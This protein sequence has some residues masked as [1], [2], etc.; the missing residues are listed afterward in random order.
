MKNVSDAQAKTPSGTTRTE[1]ILDD[2]SVLVGQISKA[3]DLCVSNLETLSSALDKKLI[4]TIVYNTE[5]LV[6]FSF[7]QSNMLM[8]I[9]GYLLGYKGINP[10][11]NAASLLG[12]IKNN[13]PL[14]LGPTEGSKFYR[15]LLE[16]I[17]AKY[18]TINGADSGTATLNIVLSSVDGGNLDSLIELIKELQNSG[19]VENIEVLT[20]I[21]SLMQKLDDLGKTELDTELISM[22]MDDVQLAIFN[23]GETFNELSNLE[24]RMSSI[25]INV[26]NTGFDTLSKFD[27][28]GN[29]TKT[30]N[31][32]VKNVNAL[33]NLINAIKRIDFK[34][35]TAS[36]TKQLDILVA[37][38]DQLYKTLNH[39]ELLSSNDYTDALDIFLNDILPYFETEKNKGLVERISGI[40]FN[41]FNKTTLKEMTSFEF[42]LLTFGDV[43]K[44]IAKML[45]IMIIIEVYKEDIFNGIN[46]INTLI[47][48]NDDY[49]GLTSL[50]QN[51]GKVSMGSRALTSFSK[52]MTSIS[53]IFTSF[54]KVGSLG[55]IAMVFKEP[56]IKA[57]K[58][59]PDIIE[60][61]NDN[62][63]VPE[64]KASID[65]IHPYAELMKDLAII[66]G[67]VTLLG[68]ISIPAIVGG[69]LLSGAIYTIFVVL[70]GAIKTI[71]KFVSNK[72]TK[73]SI[74][75]MK[76]VIVSISLLMIFASI[77]G[78][79][80]LEYWDNILIFLGMFTAFTVAVLGTITL[81]GGLV[82]KLGAKGGI[83]ALSDLSNI[84]VTCTFCMLAGALFMMIPNIESYIWSFTG[85]LAGFVAALLGTFLLVSLISGKRMQAQ[86]DAFTDIIFACTGALMIGALFMMIPNMWVHVIEFGILLFVFT[87]AIL[88]TFLW[89]SK[90]GG[91][92]IKAQMDEFSKLVAICA[93]VLIVGALFMMIP[94]YR[95]NAWIF[96]L[97]LG[98][99]VFAIVGTI[100]LYSR[101]AKHATLAALSLMLFTTITAATLMYGANFIAENGTENIL[102]F[103]GIVAGFTILMVLSMILLTKFAKNIVIGTLC[104]IALVGV[105]YLIGFALEKIAEAYTVFKDPGEAFICLG[106]TAAVI[107]TFAGVIFGIGA[108]MGTGVG[109]A[110]FAAGVAALAA[111][112]GAVWTVGEAMKSISDGIKSIKALSKEEDTINVDNIKNLIVSVKD[113]AENFDVLDKISFKNIER[114]SKIIKTISMSISSIS[115]VIKDTASLKIPIYNNDGSISGYRKLTQEDFKLVSDNVGL[116]VTSLADA[117][118][119]AY[120]KN[121]KVFRGNRTKKVIKAVKGVSNILDNIANG[122]IALSNLEIPAYKEDGSLASGT[123]KLQMKTI[124]GLSKNVEMIITSFCGALTSAYEKNEELFKEFR[125]RKVLKALRGVTSIINTF[126]DAIIK[127]ANSEY[128]QYDANGNP[129]GKKVHINGTIINQMKGSIETLITAVLGSISEI[130]AKPETQALFTGRNL[131]NATNAIKNVSAIIGG[132]G[133]DIVDLAGLYI[134]DENGK[135][136][137]MNATHFAKAKQNLKDI[138]TCILG[139]VDDLS[140]DENFKKFTE[141]GGLFGSNSWNVP[142]NIKNNLDK[143]KPLIDSAIE[144]INSINEAVKLLTPSEGGNSPD[145]SWT[146]LLSVIFDPLNSFEVEDG[147]AAK[148]KKESIRKSLENARSIIN[149]INRL[150]EDKADKFI[151]LSNELRDLSLNVG[152]MTGFIEA[153]NGKINDTLNKV[154]EC[155]IESTKALQKSDEAHDKRNEVIKKNTAELKKVLE[156]PMKENVI[157]TTGG[158]TETSFA[159]ASIGGSDGLSGLSYKTPDISTDLSG[160]TA[161]QSSTPPIDN[162]TLTSIAGNTADILAALRELLEKQ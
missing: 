38:I 140:K 116:I 156:T 31:N 51:I 20:A 24:R 121:Q 158:S 58:L 90:I 13:E 68:V 35:I 11:T 91:R 2:I 41:K 118:G 81:I 75:S 56:F 117:L 66:F 6:E 12:K 82:N 7:T 108:L 92:K 10:T 28:D 159:D 139:A 160:S 57:I 45:P 52:I 106:W 149:E 27:F 96:A 65:N 112:G 97:T 88:A 47:E 142:T 130:Y 145:K 119:N 44:S 73:T 64:I 9:A 83:E 79:I 25:D 26:I 4:E 111:L 152:D 60:I 127:F 53:D 147:A 22:K 42:T 125:L 136:V 69:L 107:A 93:G 48:G 138:I 154:S 67:Y 134:K 135:V 5:A 19:N 14:F 15:D 146:K 8:S 84:I 128:P 155:L 148:K 161:A 150:D 143:V 151:Q 63:S 36:K 43:L 29:L 122:I 86:L 133:K 153:L 72:D 1:E 87:N 137:Q 132:L 18:S 100:I 70:D 109:A 3:E 77:M 99:F 39:I 98:V 110:L 33:P 131:T 105:S 76:T 104:M 101:Y 17:L 120:D 89:I 40:P 94:T 62:V 115:G 21:Q 80:V 50:L 162:S 61:I 102:I 74:E 37:I 23:I 55:F 123:T 71:Q 126:T 103:G 34:G 157:T 114:S 16:E 85:L 129:T 49:D 141:S 95:E 124:Q 78:G 113:I 32:I 59:L 144:N 54:I 46:V 30:I